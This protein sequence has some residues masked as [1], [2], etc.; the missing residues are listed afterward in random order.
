MMCDV[1]TAHLIIPILEYR[2]ARGNSCPSTSNIIFPL[3]NPFR[4]LILPHLLPRVSHGAINVG[5]LSESVA[6][7]GW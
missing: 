7:Q 3:L 6:K 5:L 1:L 4:V 2:L